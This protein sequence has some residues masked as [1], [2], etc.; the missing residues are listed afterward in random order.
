MRRLLLV[1]TA[2][3]P[4]SGLAQTPV[5]SSP[6]TA[7][8]A[9][10]AAIAAEA[11][12]ARQAEAA[13]L[14]KATAAVQPGGDGSSLNVTA[15]GGT[16]SLTQAARAA[17][18]KTVED[19]GAKGDCST[20]DTAA[21]NAYAT[22]LRGQSG[23]LG[24]AREFSLAH[25]RCYILAG[26]VNLTALPNLV[27]DG[28]ESTLVGQ[29]SAYAV[30]D[31]VQSPQATF[32]NF[33]LIGVGALDGIQIGRALNGLSG[34]Q[35]D[36]FHNVFLDGTFTRAAIYNRAAE[37]SLYDNVFATN[38]LNAAGA[39]AAIFDGDAYWPIVSQFTATYN[40]SN[41]TVAD[42]LYGNSP[43]VSFNENTVI[44][45][46]FLSYYAPAIWM[47]NFRGLEFDNPY[48]AGYYASLSGPGQGPAAVL[49]FG[50]NDAPAQLRWKVHAEGGISSDIQFAGVQTAPTLNGFDYENHV[51]STFGSA[52]SLGGSAT[53]AK[54]TDTRIRVAT[55]FKAAATMFDSSA[56]W[57]VSGLVS[58]PL[59]NWN[60][61][62]T[63]NGLLDTG[64]GPT[65]SGALGNVTASALAAG[66]L[67]TSALG[68]PGAV[69]AVSV[70]TPTTN[71]S[72]WTNYALAGALPLVTLTSS[73]GLGGGA[74]AALQ[75]LVL[76][77][78]PA[79]TGGVGCSAGDT[80]NVIDPQT[81]GNLVGGGNLIL[82][83]TTVSSGA[84]TAVG[85]S[86]SSG[87]AYYWLKPLSALTAVTAKSSTCTTLPTLTQSNG[88]P[89]AIWEIVNSGGG[90]KSTL[91]F[92]PGSGY[93][94]TPTYA[95]TPAPGTSYSGGAALSITLN[96]NMTVGAGGAQVAFGPTGTK[97]GVSGTT[98]S[99]VI[100]QGALIDGSTTAPYAL[101][102]SGY[103]IPANVTRQR[104]KPASTLASAT[105]TL[106][107]PTVDNFRLEIPFLVNG[108]TALTFSPAVTGWTNGSTQAGNSKLVLG[109]DLTT[110][111]WYREQ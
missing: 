21:F 29:V 85:V 69:S 59:A 107:A 18:Y 98:G 11:T 92:I 47:S 72:I 4:F 71:P 41:P 27:F 84:V 7:V 1:G 91:T 58:V 82:T 34:A 62:N 66:S 35:S 13:A 38:R 83:A 70:A 77:S 16:A 111:A 108:V 103:T 67:S 93:T 30:L 36:A 23:Y 87:N 42:A 76:N 105:I 88:Y 33:T 57:T 43:N 12:T 56:A 102:T 3:W 40:P 14:A 109:Y 89:T 53:S 24:Y 2:L 51:D 106:T 8:T 96:A 9:N 37:T 81:G 60:G 104:F 73:N 94:V 55:F 49:Y 101:T 26:S 6:S 95:F 52:L 22:A 5:G 63:V 10:A 48:V 31:A 97:I 100:S 110:A 75:N 50:A 19:Y 80:F 44:G 45:G 17:I 54:I 39:Y 65:F 25:G 68:N 86:A 32:Q 99:P 64:S 90:L 61:T 46:S 78:P 15:T 74:T 79:L 20:D 28:H